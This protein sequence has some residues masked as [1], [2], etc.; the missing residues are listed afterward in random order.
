VAH[1]KQ[2]EPAGL[3]DGEAEFDLSTVELTAGEMQKAEG[4]R[5]AFRILL[6]AFYRL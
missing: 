3:G 2:D 5:A 4:R 6:T 1:E